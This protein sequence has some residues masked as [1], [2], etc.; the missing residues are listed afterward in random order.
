MALVV[1]INVEGICDIDLVWYQE[2]GFWFTE[3][4]SQVDSEELVTIL[5]HYKK[6][7]KE[8]NKSKK[9]I[10]EVV[11]DIVKV[12][13]GDVQQNYEVSFAEINDK[14]IFSEE[15]DD[16]TDDTDDVEGS[17]KINSGISSKKLLN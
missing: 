9:Q 4:G 11:P 5:N 14:D 2:E 3:Y 17:S 16:D 1:T 12:I 15:D 7:S 8:V 6:L 13:F 10:K